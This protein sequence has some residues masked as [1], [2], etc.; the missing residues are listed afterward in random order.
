MS[1]TGRY[2][3]IGA[4]P[5]GLAVARSL[6]LANIPFDQV[7]ATDDVG[8]NWYHGTYESAH[9]LSSRNVTEYPDFP[10]PADYPDFPSREQMYQ[11]YKSYASHHGLTKHIRF[12]T[13]VVR[14][15]PVG[16]SLWKA[17]FEDGSSRIFKG[18]IICNGHHW[19]KSFPTYPGSF[20]GESI[21]SKDYKSV[22]QIKNKR[23]LVVGAGNSAFDIASECARNAA[24]CTMSMRRGVWIFP[25]TF[26]GKPLS[27]V[28]SPFLAKLPDWAKEALA[29]LMIKV[30]VG[31][32]QNYGLPAP[33][34]GIFERHPTINTD[35]L[36]LIKHGRIKIKGAVRKLDHS[37][38]EFE[39]GTRDNCD[40]IVY[41]TGYNVSFP[42]LPA[43][44]NRVKEKTVKVYG[45]GLLDDYKGIYYVGWFQP[46]GG[47][48]SL[49][50]PYADL[51]AQLIRIQDVHKTPVGL[52][53]KEMGERL[54]DNHLFGGPAFLIWINKMMSK[55]PKIE[56]KAAKLDATTGEF[57]NPVLLEKQEL[58]DEL[59]TARS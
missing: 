57:E 35:T 14:V 2:L 30:T 17:T 51:L 52:A 29:K 46:R 49:I 33:S 39:D 5:C 58:I 1:E 37:T 4:G 20:S 42:F 8:G 38:V 56:R 28:N 47:I 40:M 10:M 11:Y 18:V 26:L 19:S 34:H 36:M 27:A 25:K 24:S 6:K 48:G 12:N 44:L 13:K 43:E 54:P 31:M 9:I 3:V 53:L 41:A 45:F 32:P 59:T 15:V 23:V 22:E 16:D 21:H 55:L 7:E 50:G